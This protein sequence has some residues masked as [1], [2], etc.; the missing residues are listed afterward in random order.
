M[1]PL[2]E[3]RL[4]TFKRTRLLRRALNSVLS[5]TYPEWRAVVLDDSSGREAAAVVEEFADNRIL[6]MPNPHNLGRVDNLNKAFAPT[7][8]VT[9]SK[10][11]CVLE[12][13]NYWD[14][15]LLAANVAAMARSSA[16]VMNRNYRLEDMYPNGETAPNEQLPV[17]DMWGSECRFIEYE[18]RVKEAFFS[19]TLGNLGYFWDLQ[20]SVDISCQMERFNEF[21]AEPM[22]A[23]VFNHPCWYESDILSTFTRFVSKSDT[24]SGEK[25]KNR[26]EQRLARLSEM[27]FHRFLLSEWKR[28]GHPVAELMALAERRGSTKQL[29]QDLAEC[30]HMPSMLRLRDSKAKMRLLKSSVL[31]GY[32]WIGSLTRRSCKTD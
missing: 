12:D 23:V 13:D 32:G 20:A 8:W 25:A 4:P 27:K 26:R 16:K 31:W 11:A 24:P 30:G 17:K 29:L 6:Y 15:D 3:I 5:Q 18:E 21:I 19:F 22:R 7:Q 2:V 10:F 14:P 28:L 1:N 9:Q